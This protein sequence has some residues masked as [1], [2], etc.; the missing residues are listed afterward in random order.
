M[1]VVE[2][3]ALKLTHA[4]T[5]PFGH[6]PTNTHTRLHTRG[7]L[8][9][10]STDTPTR[11]HNLS[12]VTHRYPVSLTGYP[13]LPW[14][15]SSPRAR[16]ARLRRPISRTCCPVTPLQP[17]PKH[18]RVSQLGVLQTSYSCPGRE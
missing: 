3:E 4:R 11:A 6:P 18:D 1:V 12:F 9:N 7:P 10:K 13:H 17:G 5:P 8:Q 16:G 14:S 2:E 15:I